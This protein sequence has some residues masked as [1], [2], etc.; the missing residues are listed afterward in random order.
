MSR[1]FSCGGVFVGKR[2]FNLFYNLILFLIYISELVIV[3][4]LF[5]VINVYIMV[6]MLGNLTEEDLF[7]EFADLL[8]KAVTWTL[9][10]IVACIVGVNVVQGLLTSAIDT[11]K[12]SALTRTAEALP[13]IGNVMGGMAEVTMGTIVLIKNGIGMAGAFIAVLI[14]AVGFCKCCCLRFCIKWRRQRYSRFRTKE[15][16]LVSAE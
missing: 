10:T 8:K 7:S 4:F 3:R 6:Q 14:C 13:W 1:I 2:D 16:P 12:R 15:L 9:R 5:P 11:V